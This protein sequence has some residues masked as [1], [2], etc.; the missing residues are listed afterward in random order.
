MLP[1]DTAADLNQRLGNI[2]TSDATGIEAEFT[3]LAT[4]DLMLSASF[5]YIDTDF[6][7]VIDSDPVTGESF[8]KSDRFTISNT[9]EIYL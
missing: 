1:G 2:G 8:D 9:T 6:K 7:E 5:G 4:E 3:Y